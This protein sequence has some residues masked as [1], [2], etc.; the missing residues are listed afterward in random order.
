MTLVHPVLHYCEVLFLKSVSLENVSKIFG[1]AVGVDGINIDIQSGEFLHFWGRVDV[2][3]Q[4]HC[5]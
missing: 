3:K 4:Q 1:N 5:E 2:E